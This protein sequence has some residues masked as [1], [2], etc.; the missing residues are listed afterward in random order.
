MEHSPEINSHL[1]GALQVLPVL[2]RK[3]GHSP[4]SMCDDGTSFSNRRYVICCYQVHIRRLNDPLT[5][6]AWNTSGELLI[7]TRWQHPIIDATL[8]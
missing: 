7:R 5:S 3:S 2:C 1:L 4:G 6:N 8:P